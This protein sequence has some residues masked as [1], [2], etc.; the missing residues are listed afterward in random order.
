MQAA[1]RNWDRVSEMPTTSSKRIAILTYGTRG[2]IEPFVALGQ[3]LLHAGY[4]VRLIAPAMAAAFVPEG[5]MEFV[6]LEGDP[7]ELAEELAREAGL[8]WPRMVRVMSKFVLQV[9]ESALRAILEACRDIDGV[10]HSFLMTD[11]GHMLAQQRGVPDLSAQFFPVFSTTGSFPAPTF[12]DWR[13]GPGYRRATHWLTEQVFR[14][15]GR[16]LYG[17]IRRAHRDLPSPT[18][19]PFH[20]GG[21]GSCPILYAFSS[22]VVPR[23]MDW[24]ETAHITGYWF[25]EPQRAWKP[26]EGLVRFLA[27]GPPPVYIGFGSYGPH[28]SQELA[29]ICSEA[30]ERCGLRAVVAAPGLGSKAGGVSS[31]MFPVEAAPHGWLFPQ[32]GAVV[33]HGGAGTTAAGLRAG[34]PNIIVPFTADQ[35]FWGRRVERLG[36]G[37]KP[38]SLRRL[39]PIELANALDLAMGDP[40]MRARSAALGEAIRSEDGVG[41]A[42]ELIRDRI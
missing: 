36:V 42:V 38:I 9:G 21:Q 24:P 18:E 23:P 4:A 39:T 40:I 25:L 41:R 12:P 30:V 19:W 22:Y 16:L 7:G 8:S 34:V 37:P 28:R 32:M 33:H 27:G 14:V 15:G 3:G 20:P 6:G 10:I 29:Q 5:T 13:L 31:H 11:A 17:R 26:P 2:D 35:A 1:A